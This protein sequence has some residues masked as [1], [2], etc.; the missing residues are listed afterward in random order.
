M[1]GGGARSG[2]SR[3]AL[4]R[5]QELGERR[6]FIATAQAFDGEMQQRILHHQQER[7]G[8]FVTLESHLDLPAV[9]TQAQ[10]YDVVVVDCLTL[11]ISN[12]LL[13]QMPTAATLKDTALK[14]T[15]HQDAPPQETAQR[16]VEAGVA[17]LCAAIAAHPAH[18]IVVTNEVGMGVVPPTP[19]GRLFRDLAG[20][21]NQQLAAVADELYLAALGVVLRLRP[22]PVETLSLAP[23][24]AL[25]Q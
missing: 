15:A 12:L 24:A 21:A 23:P 25:E 6:A 5:A 8:A 19:L 20:R 1:V 17:A 3:F 2:K 7:A 4:Q 16:C 11:F 22:H 9:L 18:V 10:D 13:A 14:D